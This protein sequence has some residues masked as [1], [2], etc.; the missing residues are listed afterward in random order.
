MEHELNIIY[1]K[2]DPES[3]IHL[4]WLHLSTVALIIHDSVVTGEKIITAWVLQ[5]TEE[6]Y[7]SL[8]M[9]PY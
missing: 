6:T 8:Q 1:H 3:I 7:P 2:L 9:D 5:P 4:T